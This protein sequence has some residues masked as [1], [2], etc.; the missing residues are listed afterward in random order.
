MAT[1]TSPG[2]SV[3]VIDQSNYAPTGP[4]T[5]PFV[6]IA[7]ATNKTS[8]AG[9]IASYTTS[10]TVNTL[11]L[12]ASQKDLLT[13]YGLP[14]F[15][16][17]A[18]GN[19]IFGSEL[20]EY[21][22]MA[23]HSAL[24]ITNQAYILRANVDLSQLNGSSSRPYA[25]PA[26]GTQWLN[27]ATTSFGIF[28]WNATTQTFNKQSPIIISSATQLNG[29]IPSS[30]V[31][32]IGSYAVNSTDVKNPIYKKAYDNSWNLIG[33]N[34]WAIK[35]PTLVGNAQANA[36]TLTNSLTI[37]GTTFTIA[38][39]Q[40]ANLVATINS[41]GL[42]GINAQL[43]N[44]YFNLF[45]NA[46][47]QSNGST[48]DGKVAIS[49][50][51]G[52]PLTNLGL[53]AGTYYSP[54][55]SYGAHYNVPAWKTSDSAP[56]PT[57]SI[58]IKTTAVNGGANFSVFRYNS[59]T[60]NWDQ[61]TAPVYSGRRNAIYNYDPTLGGLGITNGSLFVKYDLLNNVTGTYKL[62][63]WN[64]NGGAT[65]V[66]GST[67]NP[68]FT[69]SNSYT[70]RVTIPGQAAWSSY[71]TVTLSGTTASG[72]ISDLLA[73]NIPYLTAALS[74]TNHITVSHTS[75]G[76]IEFVNVSGTPLTAAG[77][78]TSLSNVYDDANQ[79]TLV[80]S[81]WGPASNLYQQG[82]QPVVAPADGTLWYYSTPLE[83]DI[84]IN[85]GTQWRGYKSSALSTDSRGY[86]LQS[87]DPLGPIISSTAPTQHTDGTALVFGDLW[88][89]TSN[90]ENYP[91]IYRWQRVSGVNQWL[92]L[93]T[94]DTTTE[95]GVLFADARWDGSGTVDPALG[96]K[97]TI[98]SLLTNDYYDLDAPNPQLYPRGILLFNT[99]RSSYNVKKYVASKFNSTNYPLQSLP[100]IAATWQSV[101]GANSNGTPYMGRKAQRNVV[102]SALKEAVDNNTAIREDQINFNLLVCPGYPELTSNLISLNNDRRNTGF[103]IAD[104]PMGLASDTTS[105]NNYVTN[106]AGASDTGEDGLVTSDSYTAVFYPGAAYTNALDGVGQV[107]VPIT[108]AILRMI[109]K[110]DQAS[111]PWFAPA[112]AL[113]GKIDNV[114]KIGYVDR[115][116]GKF[117]SI[118]TNQG[119]R[120][121]LYSNN[122]NPVAVFPTEG[123]LNYGNHTRQATATALDRINVARLINYLRYNLE[124]IAKPLVFEPNDTVT[125]N[126]ATNA[127]AALLNDVKTQRGVYDYLVVCDTTNNTPATIDR[128]ELHIDIAIEPTKAVEFI[129]I[130]VRILNTGAIAGTNANQGGLSNIT[131]SVSLGV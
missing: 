127:V 77:I 111:A 78:T 121:L 6:L 29:S 46:L 113:R 97:P 44:G 5:V 130:P 55:L 1:L 81:N 48:A 14:N 32:T 92:Q 15:P 86:N 67:T 23:A 51:S 52:T 31:G 98:V 108:H 54:A 24:G 53:A 28:E 89:N 85:D 69:A 61:I 56:H 7:T 110:S 63:Q 60:V 118:G 2:V 30:N 64:G 49:N 91:Q 8:T 90:L 20:A 82:T 39:T 126:I 59:S 96:D 100:A 87:T 88:I 22:L 4:G 68:T 12:L 34:A 122:V 93:D 43:I 80:G 74:S 99:R 42:A 120:D 94:T 26:G 35:T 19:R 129:Y 73:A 105:V 27:T 131:P 11:Q 41:S 45:A 66:T 25:E 70:V 117:Y 40:V 16:T 62:L 106:V 3:S 109:I 37:N 71:Y 125:R 123:I 107:V 21:G 33:S 103:V 102:V 112:G 18:S 116:T 65:V 114:I 104:T 9:G 13:N 84:M 75:G 57:G 83:V 76:D 72:F 119:L 17:D 95:N 115:T 36:L 38:N 124:R 50:S 79:G 128:N 10:S 101:S 58:W 47:S